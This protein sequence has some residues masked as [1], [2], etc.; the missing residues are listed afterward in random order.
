MNEGVD[1]GLGGDV[2]DAAA[3]AEHRDEVVARVAEHAGDVARQLAVLQGGDY[4]RESFSTDRGTWTVKYEA[5]DLEFLLYEGRGGAETYV[6]STKRPPDPDELARAMR[7]YPAFVAAYNE[8]VASLEGVFDDVA[9]DFP[10]VASTESVVAERERILGDVRDACDA[11]AGQLHRYGGTDYG[12]F[13]TRVAGTRWELKWEG[14][15]TSYLRVGGSGGTY[16]LSQYGPPSAPDVRELV[17]SFPGFVEA[18][19]D[20]VAGLD[21]DLSQ[22]SLGSDAAGD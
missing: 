5:G 10:D 8:H 18:Y 19:N 15:R 2:T 7:D 13:S 11:I 22:V 12:T 21:A 16:L 1:G 20:H 3:V 9:T 14:D 6:V 4:G 17:G